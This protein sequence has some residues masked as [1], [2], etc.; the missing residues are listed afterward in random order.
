MLIERWLIEWKERYK[1]TFK[2]TF[3][4]RSIVQSFAQ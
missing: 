4:L 1:L 2:E 3:I